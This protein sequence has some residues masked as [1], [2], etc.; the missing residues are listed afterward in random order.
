LTP[1]S[2]PGGAAWLTASAAT[3]FSAVS[4]SPELIA[5]ISWPP[6]RLDAEHVAAVDRV[7]P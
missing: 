7:R 2:V 5:S 4:R 3:Y 1:G 6:Y